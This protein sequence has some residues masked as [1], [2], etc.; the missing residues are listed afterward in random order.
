MST[1]LDPSQ[2]SSPLA[3]GFILSSDR[4]SAEKFFKYKGQDLKITVHFPS[5]VKTD[6]ARN[7]RLKEFNQTLLEKI[8]SFVIDQGLGTKKKEGLLNSISFDYK[9]KKLKAFKKHFQ[10]TNQSKEIQIEAYLRHTVDKASKIATDA[11]LTPQEK[12]KKKEKNL[13]KKQDLEGIVKHWKRI[14]LTPQEMRDREEEM[15]SRET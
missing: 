8:G 14:H 7:I 5:S 4:R 1:P 13:R 11:N 9:G 12:T 2:R 6:T 15:R 3:Y 10:G